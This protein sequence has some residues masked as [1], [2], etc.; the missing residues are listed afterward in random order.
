MFALT[1][2][3]FVCVCGVCV[4]AL[5]RREK[6]HSGARS[7]HRGEEIAPDGVGCHPTC[8]EWCTCCCCMCAVFVMSCDVCVRVG[9]AFLAL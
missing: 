5:L 2:V 9:C 7:F 3:C 8:A 1:V 6:E 4:V